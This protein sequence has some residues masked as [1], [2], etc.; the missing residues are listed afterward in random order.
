MVSISTLVRSVKGESE[1]DIEHQLETSV[2]GRAVLIHSKRVVPG[3]G[4]FFHEPVLD[5]TPHTTSRDNENDPAEPLGH[6]LR[7]RITDFSLFPKLKLQRWKLIEDLP[8][9]PK[10][11]HVK[12]NGG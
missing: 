5:L 8:K 11:Q 12:P 9:R 10:V 1:I 3:R 2:D 6:N 4:T 7:L